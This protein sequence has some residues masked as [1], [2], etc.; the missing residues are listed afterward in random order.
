[1]SVTPDLLEA[2]IGATRARVDAAIE[3]EPLQ[4]LEQRAMARTPN[5]AAFAG[6]LSRSGSINVIA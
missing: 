5:G 6:R 2:I 4:A 1:V 3:R